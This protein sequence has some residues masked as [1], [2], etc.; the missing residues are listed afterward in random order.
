MPEMLDAIMLVP[1]QDPSPLQW[2]VPNEKS[3]TP[4]VEVPSSGQIV[5]QEVT[6]A[7]V[8]TVLKNLDFVLSQPFLKNLYV[9]QLEFDRNVNV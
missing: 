9:L 5:P 4:L 1:T 8:S 3:T 6:D 7:S 2:S